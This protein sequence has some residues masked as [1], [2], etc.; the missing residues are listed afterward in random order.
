MLSQKRLCDGKTTE[1]RGAESKEGNDKKQDDAK[2]DQGVL[3]VTQDKELD[4][5]TALDLFHPYVRIFI[6]TAPTPD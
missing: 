6:L 1:A 4:R 5:L 2:E 3:D